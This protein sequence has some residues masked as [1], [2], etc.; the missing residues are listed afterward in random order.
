MSE[1]KLNMRYP[2][3]RPEDITDAYMRG[4]EFG[5]AMRTGAIDQSEIEQSIVDLWAAVSDLKEWVDAHKNGITQED[6]Y[7]REFVYW[8]VNKEPL[9]RLDVLERRVE[10]IE[11]LLS[12]KTGK[13]DSNQ[14]E[15]GGADVP[16]DD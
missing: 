3:S 6:F 14:E 15:P 12:H 4:V 13:H 8:A 2:E 16:A 9:E 1:I 5:R 11:K 10:R 7:A